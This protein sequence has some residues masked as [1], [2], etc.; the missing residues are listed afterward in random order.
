[1]AASVEGSL[2]STYMA[3]NTFINKRD[4]RKK[5][6]P[7]YNEQNLFDFLHFTNRTKETDNSRFNWHELSY[8]YGYGEVLSATGF[9]GAGIAGTVTLKAT[10][11]QESGTKSSG[12]QWD[13]IL[14]NK[15]RGWVTSTNKT[16]NSAHVY[17][18]QPVRS[19]DNFGATAGL[20][21]LVIAFF[22]TAKSD[23]SSQVGSTI[24]K[25]DLY[26]NNTQ[27]FSTQYLA[28]GSES[29]NKAEIE[30]GG[31]NF[32]YL[33]GEEDAAVKHNNDMNFAFILGEM[34]D[35]TL[36]D[37]GNANE[38]VNTTRGMEAYIRDFGNNLQYT[39]IDVAFMQSVEKTLSK[40][41]APAEMLV[42]NGVNI[43][44]LMDA[45]LQGQMA[46][47]GI[48]Y[49]QFGNGNAAARAVDFGFSSFRFSKHT[50]HKMCADFMNYSPVT[51]NAITGQGSPY[52]DMSL[53]L[54]MDKVANPKP[55]GA[56]D[57]DYI[58][59]LAVRF[60]RND[61]QNRYVKHW[62]RDITITNKDQIEFNYLSDCGLQFARLNQAIRLFR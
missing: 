25:P 17:S 16:V 61:R 30:I 6:F 11:H 50:Y 9:A 45:F 21:N 53:I 57:D 46:T 34:G 24:R 1:M 52:P 39:V 33:Q 26:F 12:K 60:K 28:N 51:G 62:T 40:E 54:P 58:D 36:L 5:I 59:T 49:T 8:L 13:L 27:I 38:P 42:V 14:L 15:I 23:G 19:T 41:R 47:T 22:S 2:N 31:K 37:T 10:S 35:G 3:T 32:F 55:T 7:R 48:Q 18:I 56:M 43:D 29:A 44:V 4:I 20:L